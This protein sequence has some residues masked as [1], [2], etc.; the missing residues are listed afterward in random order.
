MNDM[1]ELNEEERS[2]NMHILEHIMQSLT[3]LVLEKQK[4]NPK[5]REN[6]IVSNSCDAISLKIQDFRDRRG[7][8]YK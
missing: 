5:N 1:N 2:L 6:N 8:K 7:W 3:M 4:P